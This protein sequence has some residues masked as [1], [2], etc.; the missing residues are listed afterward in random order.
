MNLPGLLDLAEEILRTWLQERGEKPL[1]ARQLRRWLLVAGAESF[2]AMTDLAKPLR[3]KLKD[4]ASEILST[5]G[6][7]GMGEVYRPSAAR[8]PALQK[9][10]RFGY[11]GRA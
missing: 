10:L 4:G 3:E 1:R 5:P 7:G 2:D 8:R 11:N 9:R 6:A